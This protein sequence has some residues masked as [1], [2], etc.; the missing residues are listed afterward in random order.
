M[1]D[2]DRIIKENI[3]AI[4]LA[5]GKKLL[6]F[7]LRNPRPIAEKLQ[8]TIEREPDFLKRVTLEDGEEI[9]LHLEFRRNS[10]PDMVYR[11]AEYRAIIQ[12]KYRVPVRQYVIYLGADKPNMKTELAENEQIRGFELKNI[13]ELPLNHVLESDVPEEIVLAILT[14]YPA[15]DA[16]KVISLILQKLKK[17]AVD[18]AALKKALQQLL[19]LSRIRKLEVQTKNQI[20]TMPITYDITTDGLYLEGR[21][22]GREEEKHKFIIRLLKETS[23]TEQQ[24]AKLADAPL[25]VVRRIKSSLENK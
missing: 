4:L 13:H 6:G 9:I 22:K 8:T 15:S 1:G 23:M 17:V 3:E 16:E 14:D 21:E 5:L 12:R 24:I 19:T 11:M 2:Y 20:K 7:E 25:E 18:E 10:E